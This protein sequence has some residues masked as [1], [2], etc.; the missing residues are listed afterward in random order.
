MRRRQ[1]AVYGYITKVIIFYEIL[2][3]FS[4]L[5]CAFI[6]Y[7]LPVNFR[8]KNSQK[9]VKLKRYCAFLKPLHFWQKIGKK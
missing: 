3:L 8:L 2:L 6:Y 4:L 7:A 9:N 1:N 5:F